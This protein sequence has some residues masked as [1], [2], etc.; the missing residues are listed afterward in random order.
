MGMARST[1]V[2]EE[3]CIYDVSGKERDQYENQDV[4][5]WIIL[6]CISE[7]GFYGMDWIAQAQDRDQW[8]V[9]LNTVLKRWVPQNVGKFLSAGNCTIGCFSRRG[10]LHEF[11]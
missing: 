2:G 10:Q 9:L 6:K 11:C 7:V 3:E 5:G 1:N 8:M 4:G